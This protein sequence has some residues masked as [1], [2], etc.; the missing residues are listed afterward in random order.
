MK[1]EVKPP[2]SPMDQEDD[3]KI[4]EENEYIPG[5]CNIGKR[6]IR[7]RREGGY[8]G[9]VLMLLL[10]VALELF[11]VP[12]GWRFMLFFPAALTAVSFL[13][14]GLKFCVNFG[15]RGVYNFGKLGKTYRVER[16]EDLKKD[17]AKATRMI[18][19]GMVIGA[20]VSV[21]YFFLPV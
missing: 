15:M 1:K 3:I 21:V 6:E 7:R 16:Q 2:A 14:S 13:Q 11:H 10:L 19:I 12:R 4:K 18:V 17:R 8:A 20:I 9:L 5:V